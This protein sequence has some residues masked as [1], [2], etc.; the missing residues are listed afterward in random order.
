MGDRPIRWLDAGTGSLVGVLGYVFIQGLL[1]SNRMQKEAPAGVV[2]Q[3]PWFAN[4]G[5]A[6]LLG[7]VFAAS[8]LVAYF[9]LRRRRGVAAPVALALAAV[10]VYL[11]LTFGLAFHGPVL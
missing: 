2:P 3:V 1:W 7:I 8:L 4:A 5:W 11:L 6:V 9:Y 10:L